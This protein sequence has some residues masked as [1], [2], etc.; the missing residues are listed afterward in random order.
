MK[1]FIHEHRFKRA[2]MTLYC[3]CGLAQRIDCAHR[4]KQEK[5]EQ[6]SNRKDGRRGVSEPIHSFLH[7]L[8]SCPPHKHHRGR[9]YN[10]SLG[11]AEPRTDQQ[12]KALHLYFEHVAAAL[13]DAGLN[14][15]QV[16]KNFSM[17][18]DWTKE[19]VKE[20]LWRTAQKRLLGKQSTTELS[21]Q[22]DI[23]S[24]YEVVNRFLAKV[25]IHVPFPTMPPGYRDTAPLKS[26]DV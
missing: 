4:W 15:E 6:I 5:Y 16:L 13:N 24:V 3:S 25:G 11:M 2:G 17:E 14:I 12:N 23:T 9:Y 22:E 8:R 19:S 20:I 21:K 7:N 10:S 26:K 18:L 1:K